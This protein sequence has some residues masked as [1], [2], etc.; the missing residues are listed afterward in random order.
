MSI[1]YTINSDRRLVY[2]IVDGVVT[3]A[4]EFYPQ[5]PNRVADLQVSRPE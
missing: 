2:I 1:H 3:V 4:N 5:R